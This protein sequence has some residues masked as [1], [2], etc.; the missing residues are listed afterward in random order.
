[1]KFTN[2]S[3]VYYFLIAEMS[4]ILLQLE[5]GLNG[6]LQEWENQKT[7]TFSVGVTV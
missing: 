2:N 7:D 3:A 6:V 5:F 1:M 4:L